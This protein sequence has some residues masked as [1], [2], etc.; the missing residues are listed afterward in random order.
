LAQADVRGGAQI[1]DRVALTVA[2]G[3]VRCASQL[4]NRFA[5]P[6][7]AAALVVHHWAVFICRR[8]QAVSHGGAGCASKVLH[9]FDRPLPAAPRR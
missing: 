8:V 1:L 4:L 9:R 2:R 5:R 6:L 7:P 3:A